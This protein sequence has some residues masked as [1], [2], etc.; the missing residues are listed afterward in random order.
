MSPSWYQSQNTRRTASAYSASMVK[1]SPSKSTEQPMRRI[2]FWMM[3]P[4]SCVQSQQ[5]SMK[6]SRP[7]SRRFLPSSFSFLS[8]LVWVAIPAWSVPRI[9]RV[10]RPR[11]RAW[12][13]MASWMESSSAWPMC[14]M[15]VT[16]GGGMVTVQSPTPGRRR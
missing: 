8:T 3:P 9:Q 14:S 6:A 4:Y 5:A 10:E 15:P 16:L 12:R 1:R 11:M 2:W 13:T 7:I